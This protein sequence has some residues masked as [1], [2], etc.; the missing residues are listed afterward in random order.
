[1][2]RADIAST[3]E[4][5]LR[6]LPGLASGAG[7]STSGASTRVEA[8]GDF[9]LALP[10]SITIAEIFVIHPLSI[11]TLPV[12]ASTAG[13]AAARRGQQKQATYAQVE[14]NGFPFV[15]FSVESDGCLGQ[16]AMTLLHALGDEAAGSIGHAALQALCASIA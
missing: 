3:Q 11:N 6:C 10:E 9:L 8:R 15:P 16:P 4:C 13:A 12:A 2:H 5:A 1:V 14:L 7:I